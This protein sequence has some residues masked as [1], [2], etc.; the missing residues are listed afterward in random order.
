MYSHDDVI[1]E[2]LQ[3]TGITHPVMAFKNLAL[4][5]GVALL[6]KKSS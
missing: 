1:P 2:T 4:A 5:S 6:G 3:L